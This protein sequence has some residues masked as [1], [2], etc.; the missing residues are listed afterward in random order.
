MIDPRNAKEHNH[1]K[2]VKHKTSKTIRN[3]YLSAKSF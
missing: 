1:Y 3:N 2:K